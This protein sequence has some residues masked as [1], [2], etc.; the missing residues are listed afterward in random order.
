M[1][2]KANKRITD[3]SLAL[4]EIHLRM[5]L[6]SIGGDR[7]WT[8]RTE[9]ANIKMKKGMK[10]RNNK[11]DGSMQYN[12]VAIKYISFFFLPFCVVD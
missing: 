8:R 9:S 4:N 12:Y 10:E 11:S 3:H 5:A 1:D 2:A 6:N 7:S